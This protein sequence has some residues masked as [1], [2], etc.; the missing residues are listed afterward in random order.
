MRYFTN[1]TD[2]LATAQMLEDETGHD[3]AVIDTCV[4]SDAGE[5]CE[6]AVVELRTERTYDL[7]TA[8]G[9]AG[10][11]DELEPD[12]HDRGRATNWDD[13]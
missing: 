1:A 2:A 6:Y 3:H 10:F 11:R 4:L 7:T 5:V 13:N 8:A 9:R 12:A